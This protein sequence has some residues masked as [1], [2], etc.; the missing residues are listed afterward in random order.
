WRAGRGVGED[1]G[2]G[3]LLEG[4]WQPGGHPAPPL[5]HGLTERAGRAARPPALQL[6]G[7]RV[8][9]Q[10]LAPAA[11]AAGEEVVHAGRVA[12]DKGVLELHARGDD[13]V[14]DPLE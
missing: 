14:A 12:L 13:L 1:R 7:V 4:G 10:F 9:D 5:G 8:D 11:V 6:E 3:G 2:R